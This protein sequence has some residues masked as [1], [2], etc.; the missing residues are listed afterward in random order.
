MADQTAFLRGIRRWRANRY[1]GAHFSVLL[2]HWFY[3]T[4]HSYKGERRYFVRVG[5]WRKNFGA[6][7]RG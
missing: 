6:V 5:E 7:R 4:N 3:F 2:T 1:G